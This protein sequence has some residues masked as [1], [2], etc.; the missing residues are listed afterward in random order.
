MVFQQCKGLLADKPQWVY[1]DNQQLQNFI[2][3]T[4]YNSKSNFPVLIEFIQYQHQYRIRSKCKYGYIYIYVY[5]DIQVQKVANKCIHISATCTYIIKQV[6]M[7]KH[8]HKY[9]SIYY[10]QVLAVHT[11]LIKY[12]IA[13]ETSNLAEKAIAQHYLATTLGLQ[14]QPSHLCQMV[15]R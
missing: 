4:L 10:I 13:Q 6:Y 7:A 8:S 2:T 11:R 3:S 15:I 9:L 14:C 12:T 1:I 5:I